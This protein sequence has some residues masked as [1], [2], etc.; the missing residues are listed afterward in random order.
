MSHH[1]PIHFSHERDRERLGGTQCG[2]DELLRVMAD[3]Q[4]LKRGDCDLGDGA[5]IGARFISDQYLVRHVA[6]FLSRLIS[7]REPCARDE[8][9][10]NPLRWEPPNIMR[11]DPGAAT[12]RSTTRI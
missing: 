8:D 4:S 10:G 3:R 9:R 5:D 7:E 2:N 11:G 12:V 1:A 6:E